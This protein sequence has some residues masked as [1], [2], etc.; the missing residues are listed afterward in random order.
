MQCRAATSKLATAGAAAQ[1]GASLA[2]ACP[3]HG[4]SNAEPF[5]QPQFPPAQHVAGVLHPVGTHR[6][7]PH[8]EAL[9]SANASRL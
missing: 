3:T 4:F 8:F 5:G 7:D 2:L 6:K 9:L 1:S